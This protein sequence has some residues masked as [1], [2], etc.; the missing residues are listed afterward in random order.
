[1]TTYILNIYKKAK[2]KPDIERF[3]RLYNNGQDGLIIRYT[4]EEIDKGFI[5]TKED[6]LIEKVADFKKDILD[7]DMKARIIKQKKIIKDGA[8]YSN[9]T[10][11]TKGAKPYEPIKK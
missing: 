6:N 11:L 8:R 9:D 3:K 4:D 2:K 5:I 7:A 1:M 10:S